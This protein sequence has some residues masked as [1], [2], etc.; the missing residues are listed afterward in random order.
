MNDM[1][2]TDK[3]YQLERFSSKGGWTY[4]ALPEIE[5]NKE[6]AFRLVKVKG[7]IDS[8][9]ISGVSLMPFGNGNL[10]LAVKAEIRKTIGREEGDYVHIRLYKDD[11]VFQIPDDFKERL[12]DEGLLEI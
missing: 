11:S 12:I 10:I 3:E 5:K 2:L 4:V 9:E 6:A 8:Y 7:V 1:L